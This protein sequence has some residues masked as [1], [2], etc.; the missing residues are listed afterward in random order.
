MQST[1]IPILRNWILINHHGFVLPVVH[2]AGLSGKGS[3]LAL[4]NRDKEKRLRFRI[5][6]F[7]A[8]WLHLF[9][10]PVLDVILAFPLKRGRISALCRTCSH[11]ELHPSKASYPIPRWTSP[12]LFQA[13]QKAAEK[14]PPISVYLWIHRH[15]LPTC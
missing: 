1:E 2:F 11:G 7:K 5:T 14:L 10:F 15:H 8:P 13:S 3:V 4:Q 9:P 12:A 6:A